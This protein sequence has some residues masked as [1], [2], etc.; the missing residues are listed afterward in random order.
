MQHEQLTHQNNK[1]YDCSVCNKI[2]DGME[3]MRDH[4]KK[5]HSY[6]RMKGKL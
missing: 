3:Q 5:Y 1:S 2:F 4:I 6:N